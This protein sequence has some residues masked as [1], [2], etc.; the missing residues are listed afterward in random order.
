MK[1]KELFESAPIGATVKFSS[2]TPKP[3][4][5]FVHKLG[6]WNAD[7]GQGR[8]VEKR[9]ARTIGNYESPAAFTLELHADAVCVFRS[10]HLVNSRLNFELA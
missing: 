3:P 7:N 9:E 1:A 2:G 8:L 5:R 6:A 4:A 10:V